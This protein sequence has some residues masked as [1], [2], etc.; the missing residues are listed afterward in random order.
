MGF[1]T[2]ID[3]MGATIIGGILLIMVNSL[4]ERAVGTNIIY[5]NDKLLQME[6]VQLADLIETDFRKIGYCEDAAKVTDSMDVI[7]SADTSQIKFLTDLNRDGNLDT[8][9]YYVSSTAVLSNTVNPRDRILYR[10][11]SAYPDEETLDISSNVTLFYLRYFDALNIELSS[12][13]TTPSLI[14]YMEISFK[15]E[16]SEAYNEEYSEAYWQQV[17]LTSRNLGKR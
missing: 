8:L 7:I 1:S 16:D 14:A 3:I 6:L 15:V 13:V 2:L 9:E 11:H 17:R 12:P 5:G 4:N 10:K